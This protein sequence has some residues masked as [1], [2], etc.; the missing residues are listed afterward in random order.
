MGGS[1]LRIYGQQV[2]R[3]IRCKVNVANTA[4]VTSAIGQW[5]GV[6]SALWFVADDRMRTKVLG[7]MVPIP[8]LPVPSVS[9]LRQ[10]CSTIDRVERPHWY[11]SMGLHQ[12]MQ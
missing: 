11:G 6:D 5:L 7:T 12:S 4:A 10:G 2:C 1:D 8:A 9:L 3:S